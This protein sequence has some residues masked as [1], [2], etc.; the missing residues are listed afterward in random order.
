VNGQKKPRMAKRARQPK[1][2]SQP[3]RAPKSLAAPKPNRAAGPDPIELEPRLTIAQAAGL[4]RT[5]V[6]RMAEGGPI[7]IDG[8]KVEEIDTAILQLLT[9]LWR[10][11]P[12]R[13]A[14]CSWQGVSNQLRRTA[15]L[16]GVAEALHLSGGEAAPVLGHAAA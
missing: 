1:R 2:Q 12:G 6:A 7:A 16:I 8:G 3:E 5:L 13:G 15:E 4:H 9:S 14:P 11:A 10:T